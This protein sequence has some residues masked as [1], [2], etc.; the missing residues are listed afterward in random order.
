MGYSKMVQAERTKGCD[1]NP[2]CACSP[3]TT[4]FYTPNRPEVPYATVGWR[5]TMAGSKL[6]LPYSRGTILARIL[7]WSWCEVP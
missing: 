4:L 2:Q 6:S 7:I 1:P 3:G 5:A